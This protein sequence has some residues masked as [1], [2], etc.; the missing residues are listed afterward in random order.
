MFVRCDTGILQ[1]GPV[2]AA[3]EKGS[4]F[5]LPDGL[6]LLPG[7]LIVNLGE[8]DFSA[9]EFLQGSM[10]AQS[11][12]SAVPFLLLLP[13]RWRDR[14]ACRQYFLNSFTI[15]RGPERDGGQGINRDS[16][17]SVQPVTGG[18]EGSDGFNGILFR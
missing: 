2:S 1:G 18:G 4:P 16:S 11:Q 14:I 12:A 15:S 5:K 10:N 8:R 3:P 9:R 13:W 6:Q 17:E 7:R